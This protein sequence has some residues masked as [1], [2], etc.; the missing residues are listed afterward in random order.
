MAGLAGL[1]TLGGCAGFRTETDRNGVT[2]EPTDATGAASTGSTASPR[3][4]GAS[5]TRTPDCSVAPRFAGI[6]VPFPTRITRETAA[7]FAGQFEE[8]YASRQ[9]DADGWTVDGVDFADT[10][11]RSV[12]R[13]YVV[14]V[15]LSLDA[16]RRTQV[17][18]AT[19]T[20]YG[21]L[22]A[23]AWYRVTSRRGERSPV[24]AAAADDWTV[25][26]CDACRAG[27]CG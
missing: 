23:E 22:P 2:A 25:V 13:G 10:S 15:T 26:A 24:P 3:T 17:G 4:D 19:E 1:V 21:S 5:P 6:D 18:T 7:A 16:H 11:V 9:A 8:R 12:E 20:L 14:H 27:A